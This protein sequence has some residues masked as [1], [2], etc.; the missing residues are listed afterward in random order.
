MEK[1]REILRKQGI[2]PWS[3]VKFEDFHKMWKMYSGIY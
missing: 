2:T 1:F 3:I